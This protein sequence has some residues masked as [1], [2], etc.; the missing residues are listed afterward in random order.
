MMCKVS[1]NVESANRAIRDGVLP[2]LMEQTMATLKPEAAYFTAVGG[3]RTAFF[4]FDLKNTSDIPSF[5]EP[6]FQ[7]LG[8]KIELSPAMNAED[9]KTGLAHVQKK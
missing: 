7:Q 4:F 2:K 5:A 9:L 8:A 3:D 6:L 1:M